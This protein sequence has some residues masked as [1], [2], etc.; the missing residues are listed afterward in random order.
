LLIA[1]ACSGSVLLNLYILSPTRRLRDRQ[2]ILPHPSEMKFNRL[3]DFGPRL[4]QRV[5]DIETA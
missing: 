1:A 3:A 4:F 5:A 2:P